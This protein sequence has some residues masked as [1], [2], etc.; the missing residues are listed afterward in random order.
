MYGS[1][2]ENVEDILG[3][4]IG[5]EIFTGLTIHAKT[6][7]KCCDF[8]CNTGLDRGPTTGDRDWIIFGN[9]RNW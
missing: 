3:K 9:E 7:G 6:P 4:L 8:Q 2:L 1:P 5:L